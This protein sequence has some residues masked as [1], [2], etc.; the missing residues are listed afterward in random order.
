MMQMETKSKMD[1][2]DQPGRKTWIR[3][4]ALVLLFNA[5]LIAFFYYLSHY[6]NAN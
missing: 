1:T 6:L 5:L 4:Y 3:T 2:A